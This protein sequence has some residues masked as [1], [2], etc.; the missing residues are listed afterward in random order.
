MSDINRQS[1][2]LAKTVI[3]SSLAPH[4]PLLMPFSGPT[5]PVVHLRGLT[6]SAK[7]RL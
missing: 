6:G 4:A 5:G 2:G 3:D 7:S 1:T